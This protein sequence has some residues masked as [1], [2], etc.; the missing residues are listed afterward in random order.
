MS[1]E[2][3][4]N[5]KDYQ[6]KDISNWFSTKKKH[7]KINEFCFCL[8]SKWVKRLLAILEL[9]KKFHKS[10]QPTDLDLVNVNQIVVSEKFK[11]SDGGLKSFIGCKEGEIVRPLC[12]N[13]PEMTGYIKY[14]ENRRKNMSFIIKDDNVLDKYNE[15]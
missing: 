5:I 14:F 6:K 11:H 15:N 4:D 3:K 7:Y 10:K 13:L 8:V 12:I 1:K 2:E 9:T